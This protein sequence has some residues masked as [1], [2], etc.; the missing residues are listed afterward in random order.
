MAL[1]I[2]DLLPY[3]NLLDITDKSVMIHDATQPNGGLTILVT[4]ANLKEQ[5]QKETQNGLSISSGNTEL[6]GSLMHPTT[7]DLMGHEMTFLNSPL[8]GFGSYPFGTYQQYVMIQDLNNNIAA[9]NALRNTAVGSESLYSGNNIKDLGDD[10]E[11]GFYNNYTLSTDEQIT[12]WRKFTPLDG[13]IRV[14][15]DKSDGFTITPF[16]Q[17]GVNTYLGQNI[18][19]IIDTLSNDI[20]KIKI[21]GNIEAQLPTH[22]DEA[23]ATLAGLP[24]NTFY[25]TPTGEVR[26]KL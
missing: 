20:F 13:E 18:F 3:T 26:I 16:S 19:K 6:G 14:G 2:S 5:I 11:C 15:L 1:K 25:K 12:Y 4:L 8:S 22:V 9:L 7:I 23:A 17:V 24:Q 21:N 10:S